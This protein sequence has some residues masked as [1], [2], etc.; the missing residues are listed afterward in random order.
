VTTSIGAFSVAQGV[1]NYDGG[2][3]VAVG[4]TYDGVG[5]NFAVARYNKDGSLDSSFGTGGIVSTDFAGGDDQATSVAVQGD[6][7]VV[8]GITTPDGGATYEFAL[9][10]YNKNGSLD[11]SFGT[12]GE[13]VTNFGDNN[14][15][16]DAVAVKGDKIVA[17]GFA[18]Y[19]FGLAQYKKN[20]SL[21][22]S[23][24]TGGLVKTDFDGNFDAAN[25]VAFRGDNIIAAGYAN[26]FSGNTNFALAA[27]NKN[28]TLDAS[29]GTGGKVETDFAGSD[30][31]GHAIDVK[32]DQILVVGEASIGGQRDFA[33]AVYDKRGAL[34]PHFNG[35]GKATLDIGGDDAAYG[36]AFGPDDTVVAAG[37][38]YNGNDRFAV[39]RWT[40]KGVPDPKFGG[41]AGFT[42]TAIGVDSLALAMTL[43]PEDKIVAAGY[44]DGNFAVARYLN[45]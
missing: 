7:I 1:T 41:G 45:K 5:D 15:F 44:S 36:G 34:D 25:A 9:A 19:D 8:A 40:K 29:F 39:A 28:G 23:F 20:G 3:T 6:K 21:D 11:S 12:G 38:T 10:R 30:D 22:S 42:T 17:A 35:T 18:N 14:D 24:G 2:K 16:A 31:A 4:L 26:Y 13:V 32:G 33:A 27:Y 37:D 43:G